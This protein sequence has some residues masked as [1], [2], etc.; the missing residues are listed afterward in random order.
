MHTKNKV[1]KSAR[2]SISGKC[3]YAVCALVAAVGALVYFRDDLPAFNLSSGLWH[4]TKHDLLTGSILVPYDE[5]I[6]RQRS[7]DNATGKIQDHGLVNCKTA[8]AKNTE[9]WGQLITE[10]RSMQIRKAFQ[11]E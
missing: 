5:D 10:Q 9:E 11:N 6:C 4:E 1:R 2:T 3:I 8:T 7:I